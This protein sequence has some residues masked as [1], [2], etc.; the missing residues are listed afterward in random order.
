MYQPFFRYIIFIY[1]IIY[2]YLDLY[3][4]IICIIFTYY[5]RLVNVIDSLDIWPS[6]WPSAHYFVSRCIPM[7]YAQL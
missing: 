1:I 7:L 5:Y 3:V 4:Y 6:V 2:I